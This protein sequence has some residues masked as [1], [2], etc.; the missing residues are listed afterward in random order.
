MDWLDDSD[1]RHWSA[2]TRKNAGVVRIHHGCCFWIYKGTYVQYMHCPK[3]HRHDCAA[4]RF[5]SFEKLLTLVVSVRLHSEPRVVRRCVKLCEGLGWCGWK[6][7]AENTSSATFSEPDFALM[8]FNKWKK[9]QKDAPKEIPSPTILFWGWDR[10]I[11]S[12]EG[13]GFWGCMVFLFQS[14]LVISLS[15]DVNFSHP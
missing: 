3:N 10:P 12:R 7:S 14:S 11:L 4:R 2:L 15:V 1:I 9:V 5:Q 8:F 6:N 13:S